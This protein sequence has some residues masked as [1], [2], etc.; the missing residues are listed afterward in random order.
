[1]HIGVC[2]CTYNRPQYIG[3]TIRMFLDQDYADRELLILDDAGQYNNAQ[4]EKWRLVSVSNRFATLGEKRNAVVGML[5]E[6]CEAFCAWDDDDAYLPWAV[7]SCAAAL[8]RGEWVVPSV[9]F[10]LTNSGKLERIVTNP[11]A[12]CV[13]A[14]WAVSMRAFRAVG[15][16]GKSIN[17]EEGSLRDRFRKAGISE[18]E[19]IAPGH[20]PYFIWR[21]SSDTYHASDFKGTDEWN[22]TVAPA[23]K[24]AIVI[25]TENPATRLLTAS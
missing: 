7:S 21:R 13:G 4:G 17:G 3:Q 8:E 23:G 12:W 16:Y 18:T 19:S 25:P 20:N 11:V 24:R 15:G 10:R 1:M 5:G 14:S 6:D 9:I 2:V 22:A